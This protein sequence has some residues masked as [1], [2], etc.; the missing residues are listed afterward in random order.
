MKWLTISGLIADI[1]G[2]I[3]LLG[4]IAFKSQKKVADE[5][6]PKI[7]KDYLKEPLD[8]TEAK[9]LFLERKNVRWGLVFLV[10]G[11]VMQIL[12]AL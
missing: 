12:G 4:G 2:T 5:V 1:L 8:R 9:M 3:V 7:N 6:T 11:F 10:L